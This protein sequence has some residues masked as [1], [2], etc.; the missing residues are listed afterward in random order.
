MLRSV[1]RLK[2][3]KI[4]AEDGEIGKVDDFFFDGDK[5]TIKYLVVEIGNWLAR[6]EVLLSPVTLGRPDW[7]AEVFPVKLTK[8]QVENSPE[9]DTEKPVSRQQEI[10]LHKHY[11]WPYYWMQAPS[12]GLGTTAV[13][14]SHYMPEPE[15]TGAATM[16]IEDVDPHLRSTKEVTDYRIQAIDGEI[17][18][19]ED[20]IVDDEI[21]MIRYLVIDTRNWL[22]GKKV[23]VSPL[24]I[25]SIEWGGAKVEVDL[26]REQIKTSP[27]FDPSMP[28]NRKYEERLYD[29]YGRPKY[30]I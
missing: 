19:V 16:V 4:Q 29:F 7:T 25:E 20:F 6:Q 10:K 5:W 22:P 21:W 28:V 2:G 30:W 18:H 9:I 1:K 3:Y 27:E 17:G 13:P 14:P 24:W 15:Q 26:T 12:P 11:G 23:L 8:K